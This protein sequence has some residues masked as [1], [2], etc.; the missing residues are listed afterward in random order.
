M[1]DDDVAGPGLAEERRQ[2]LFRLFGAIGDGTIDQ[3]D[4]QR[5]QVLLTNDPRAR[6]LWFTYNDLE[7]GLD[8]WSAA[9]PRSVPAD[10]LRAVEAPRAAAGGALVDGRGPRRPARAGPRLL[11]PRWWSVAAAAALVVAGLA[12]ATHTLPVAPPATAAAFAALS[13]EIDARWGDEASSRLLAAGVLP[14]DLVHL[15]SGSAQFTFASGATV[16]V[17]GPAEF[18]LRGPRRI[19]MLSGR[20]LCRCPL[21]PSR[22][23]VA[24]PA[25]E[26]T[27]LGTE[28]VVDAGG[29]KQTRIAV[30][31]GEVL[32][33]RNGQRFH[34]RTGQT[35]AVSLDG[36][37]EYDAPFRDRFLPIVKVDDE[38]R[39][40]TPAGENLLVDPGFETGSLTSGV[41]GPGSWHGTGG[42]TAR[43]PGRGRAGSVAARINAVA[44]LTYPLIRQLITITDIGGRE[45]RA[46]V[47]VEQP[48]E[49]PLREG[50]SAILKLTFRDH[51][52]HYAWAQRRLPAPPTAAG[53]FQESHLSAIAPAGTDQVLFEVLLNSAG[54]RNGSI[55]ID[56]AALAVAPAGTSLP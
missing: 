55:L 24:T 5:L 38:G 43:L 18:A 34:M 41:A 42:A 49:N 17:E 2:E 10:A 46:S 52:G 27:D 48:R 13:G 32:I 19:E 20:V 39:P 4:H 37:V 9:Q 35:L 56:D 21:E 6:R 54:S 16:V 28:F 11:R 1:T 50:Q 26:V 33:A 15:I 23:T 47:W 7:A 31:Q 25:M 3:D 22:L 36:Q 29:G 12:L 51:A 40:G 45:V 8:T 53:G 30:I 44:G 14:S